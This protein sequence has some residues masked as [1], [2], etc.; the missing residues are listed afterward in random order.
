[1]FA[2]PSAVRSLRRAGAGLVLATVVS[3]AVPAA[4]ATTTTG[5]PR[6]ATTTPRPATTSTV[7]ASTSSTR[8]VGASAQPAGPE[9]AAWILVDAGTGNVLAEHRSHSPERPASMAKVMTALAA[10]ERLAPDAPVVVSANAVAHAGQNREPSGMVAG[11]QWPLSLTLATLLIT[12]CNDAAYALA[13]TTSGSV[14]KFAEAETV[15]G[16]R[17]GLR[18]STFNDPSGLDDSTS[19]GGG[20]RMSPFDVAITVRNALAVPQIAQWAR[21]QHYTYTDLSGTV[22][23]VTNHNKMLPGGAKAYDGVTGF[24]TGF[25]R[26]AGNTLATSAT[27]KGRTLIV[28]VMQTADPVGWTAKFLDDGFAT[29]VGATGTGAQLPPVRI[30]T[31]ADRS[32]LRTSFLALASGTTTTTTTPSGAAG[33]GTNTSGTNTSGTTAVVGGA[34]AGSATTQRSAATTTKRA[35]AA[36]GD[37]SGGIGT[38]IV[39]VVVGVLGV[40]IALRRRAVRRRKARRQAQRRRTQAAL[41]RGS[42]PVVDGRYRA[43]MRTGPPVQSNVRVRRYDD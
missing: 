37:S 33:S 31:Y 25:T 32:S 41:R 5:A 27:R 40:L 2:R 19:Y 14:A 21:T 13:E 24:K 22:H 35:A 1:M 12:S 16:R 38:T 3:P 34:G 29:P 17:L 6:T 39:L 36:S 7:P 23:N 10:V 15:T 30:T 4:A 26:R 11:Q 18:D 8:P 20:P 9:P 28:V 43:G 42:L